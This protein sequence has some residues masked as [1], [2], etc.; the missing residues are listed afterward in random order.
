MNGCK[1]YCICWEPNYQQLT[2][3]H[4]QKMKISMTYGS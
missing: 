4:A 3:K 1:K 2:V